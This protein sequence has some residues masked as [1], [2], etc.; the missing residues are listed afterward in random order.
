[1]PL[2][3]LARFRSGTSPVFAKSRSPSF[4]GVRY[5]WAVRV[6]GAVPPLMFPAARIACG[7]GRSSPRN[8]SPDHPERR[9]PELAGVPPASSGFAKRQIELMSIP[10]SMV[11]GVA[12]CALSTGLD[13]VVAKV[14][15]LAWTRS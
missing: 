7:H 8:S 14:H 10:R 3:E 6:F 12:Q 5:P 11:G 4:A 2:A 9:S 13:Q 15:A 1:M